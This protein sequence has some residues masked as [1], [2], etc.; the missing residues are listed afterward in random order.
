VVASVLRLIGWLV[1]VVVVLIMTVNGAVMVVS[2]K[3]WFRLPASIRMTG[4][5]RRE[6]HSSGWGGLEVRLGGLLVLII[7]AIILY[8]AFGKP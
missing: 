7:M 1:L 6:R 4:T 2:P 5:L 3:T 8:E